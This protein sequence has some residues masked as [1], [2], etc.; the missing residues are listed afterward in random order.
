MRQKLYRFEVDQSNRIEEF[1][2]D[3][4]IGIANAENEFTAVISKALKRRLYELARR[5]KPGKPKFFAPRLFARAIVAAIAEAPFE[6]RELIVD[7]EYPG[8]ERVIVSTIERLAPGV[9]VYFKPIGK[10]SPAHFAAHGVHIGKKKAAWQITEAVVEALKTRD[11]QRTVTH[12]DE[13]QTIRSPRR[14]LGNATVPGGDELSMKP[15]DGLWTK[16]SGMHE[17][18]EIAVQGGGAASG[19]AAWD[20][21]VSIER[22][23]AEQVWGL[24][25]AGT[26]KFVAN[27]IV[28]HQTYLGTVSAS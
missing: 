10:K 23:P 3:T 28:A 9:V 4:I 8:Y 19:R 27:G 5:D 15:G 20:R 6:V 25:I 13:S 26:H 7:I 24:E 12:L 2:R 21:I 14:P 16:V 1:T 17:G 18:Q 11:G 22:L